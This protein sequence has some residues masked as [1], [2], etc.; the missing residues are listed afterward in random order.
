MEET[1]L[2]NKEVKGFKKFV[3]LTWEFLEVIIIAV[4]IVVPIRY[5][6]FQPFIVKGESMVPNFQS[7]DYLIVDEISYRFSEPQRGDVVVFRYPL[8][9]NQ[10]FIKRVIGLP[11][12]TV[13]VK[14][15]GI[16]ISKDGKEIILK[17]EYLSG[18]SLTEGDKTLT[19]KKDEYFVMGDNRRFSYDSRNWG[20]LPQ[21]DIIGRAIFRLFP[22]T[23]IS[24]IPYIP[25]L[26]Y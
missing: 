1:G 17:E 26:V 15:N 13:N 23:K 16:T 19:L 7:G 20:V 6:I 21:K 8:D 25:D 9:P 14:D 22:I 2:N 10:K 5:F 12:E 4:A 24:Y 11:G 3:L 18:S